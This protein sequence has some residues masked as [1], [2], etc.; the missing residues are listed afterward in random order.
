MSWQRILGIFFRYFYVMRKGLHHLADLFY[1]PT[2]DILLWG[3]TSIWI[4]SQNFAVPNMPL[5]LLTGLIFWQICWRGS[6]DIS[7]CLLQEFWQRN[8]VNLFSTPLK[9]S[10]WIAGVLLL[11]V[12]KL[13]I[14]IGFASF[15]IYILYTLNVFTVGW[16]FLPFAASLLVFGWTIGFLAASSIIYFGHT[17]EMFAWMAGS[18]FAPFS[19]IYYPVAILPAWAQAISWCMPTTYIFEGMRQ[20]LHSGTFSASYFWMSIGLNIV[21]LAG[22]ILLFRTM[23]ELSRNKGLGRLE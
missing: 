22:A 10:E 18:L 14:T 15:M 6:V 7:V 9:I 12:C 13:F 23:F 16:A 1:F 21:Y 17:V 20:I 11:S 4:Q 3:L 19:A 8:L 5:I 2:V